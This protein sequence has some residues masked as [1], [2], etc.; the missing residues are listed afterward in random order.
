MMNLT[1]LR[2]DRAWVTKISLLAANDKEAEHALN[3]IQLLNTIISDVADSG[4][5]IIEANRDGS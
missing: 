2:E 5:C 4:E 3:I 1:T